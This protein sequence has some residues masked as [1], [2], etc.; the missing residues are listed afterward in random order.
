IKIDFTELSGHAG[1]KVKYPNHN[2]FVC[3]YGDG[4]DD[5]GVELRIQVPRDVNLN[6]DGYKP[7]MFINGTHGDLHITSYKSDMRIQSVRGAVYIDTYKNRI[8]MK[9]VDV[10]GRL[11]VKTYSGEV[12][13]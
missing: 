4:L 6:I 8:E 13:A 9:D 1:V 5:S 2:C 12:D 3:W 10:Q 11:Y 7:D